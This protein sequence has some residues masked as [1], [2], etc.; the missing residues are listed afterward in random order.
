[1]TDARDPEEGMTY[2]ERLDFREQAH[3]HDLAKLEKQTARDV[4][5]ARERRLQE[6]QE[7]IRNVGLAL[8]AVLGVAV[9][10]AAI[11]YWAMGGPPSP[12]GLSENERREQA[13]VSSG[14]GWVPE[15]LLTSSGQG[16]CVYPGKSVPESE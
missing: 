12:D 6:R 10:L 7:T 15:D 9:I 4:A 16:L 5:V 8:V 3:R 11:T 13:C 1:M 14:G 2:V